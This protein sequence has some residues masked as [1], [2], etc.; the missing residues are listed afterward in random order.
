MSGR[1]LAVDLLRAQPDREMQR[2]R[3]AGEAD[4]IFPA[5]V[6]RDPLLGLVDVRADGRDPVCLDRL[7]YVFLLVSVHCRGGEPDFLFE[8][9][10]CELVVL[11]YFYSLDYG[12][13]ELSLI[14]AVVSLFAL[15]CFTVLSILSTHLVRNSSSHDDFS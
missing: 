3:A 10:H 2:R 7:I 15:G 8:S 4:G 5:H 9:L 1:R 11:S 13:F 12:F 6:I 14:C